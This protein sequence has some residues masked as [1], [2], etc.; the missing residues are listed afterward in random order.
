MEFG[1]KMGPFAGYAMPL[2]YPLGLIKEHLHT[3]INAGLFDISHMVH[4]EISGPG[5]AAFIE[6]ACPY[7]ASD[8]LLANA[9]THFFSMTK[10][11]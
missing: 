11:A 9:N 2:F 3:R 5:A 7:F 1:A 6:R 4:V 8:N 10:P